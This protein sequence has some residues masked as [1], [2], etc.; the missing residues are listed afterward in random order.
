MSSA[1][2]N[3]YLAEPDI[4][5]ENWSLQEPTWNKLNHDIGG[6][7]GF[8]P[9]TIKAFYLFGVLLAVFNSVEYLLE[10]GRLPQITYLPAYSLFASG[11]DIFGRC[12]R[13]NSRVWNSSKDI[14]AG[15]KWLADP[16]FDT[17]MNVVDQLVLIS[18]TNG[19]YTIAELISM[20][21]FAS[22][23]QATSSQ[24]LPQ[25]DYLI[26]AE[27]PPII[28]RAL[29]SYWSALQNSPVACNMLAQANILPYRN[30]PIFDALWSISG[31]SPGDYPALGDLYGSLDWT[32]KQPRFGIADA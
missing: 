23:G 19:P 24:P 5:V 15:F 32:F 14:L 6:N 28:A 8:Y 3:V 22:H 29:E 9:I 25:L 26:L 17:Y 12:I 16:S 21:H 13:G 18:T 10:E 20:R 11:I 30:R 4:D 2:V 31:E 7:P 1:P 27:M